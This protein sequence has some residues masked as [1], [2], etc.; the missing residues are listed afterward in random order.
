MYTKVLISIGLAGV[1]ALAAEVPAYKLKVFKPLPAAM[2]SATNPPS[3]AKLELG[4]MLYFENRL[5]KSQKFSCNSCH[6][7]DKFGV[8]NQPTSEGHKGQ[9]GDRNSPTVFNAALHMAQFWDGRAADVEAQAKGPV[10]NPVEMAMPDE[11]T[12][13]KTLKSMPEY[14]AL[15][16]KAFPGQKD[17]VTYDN[18]AKAIGAFERKLVTPSRWDKFLAGDKTALSEQEQAGL[19]KFLDAGCAGCHSGTL[20]GGSSYQKLGAAH[21]YPGLKDEGRSKVSK[22][23]G[24]KFYFKVPSL[25]NIDRTAPYYHDG[26]VKSLDEAVNRMAE[27]QL[28]SKLAPADVSAIVTWLKSL[29]GEVPASLIAK[30][31][32]PASTPQ[33]PKPDTTD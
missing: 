19:A 24:E 28:G 20:L 18:M 13:V 14:T 17:P 2:D 11:Q 22:N 8:D 12:V 32:L 26:S 30:P 16:A 1:C 9:R 4:R 33:T 25:R 29:T 7:L 31:K 10:L 21:P 15:F 6:M 23:A 5:S 3:Q 27:F